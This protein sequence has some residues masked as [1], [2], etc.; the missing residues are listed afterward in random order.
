LITSLGS[1]TAAGQ[2]PGPP[3]ADTGGPPSVPMSRPAPDPRPR[4]PWR[5]AGPAWNL[6]HG[7]RR[8]RIRRHR[9]SA[10]DD[11]TGEVWGFGVW[12]LGEALPPCPSGGCGDRGRRARASPPRHPI[13]RSAR[14]GGRAAG[15]RALGPAA[16]AGSAGVRD[17]LHPTRIYVHEWR[18]DTARYWYRAA[19][20]F[21][22]RRR[23]QPSKAARS[24]PS[25][26]DAS[27]M[28]LGIRAGPLILLLPQDSQAL[29][30]GRGQTRWRKCTGCHT[31]T[32]HP[33]DSVISRGQ[34]GQLRKIPSLPSRIWVASLS[35]TL[36][37]NVSTTSLRG[38]AGISRES[39][40]A[41]ED[42]FPL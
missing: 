39:S 17:A 31:S 42:G 7:G 35:S 9:R 6:R 24:S 10:A 8:G 38:P 19:I 21:S 2:P 29:C 18:L 30:A 11:G 23:V 16:H 36:P 34:S 1:V 13:A 12:G 40:P 25:R 32:V 33:Q 3:P 37:R 26:P 4:A 22:S 28:F 15:P 5:A 41:A 27:W 14:R 20:L